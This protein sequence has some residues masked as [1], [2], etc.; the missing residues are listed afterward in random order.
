MFKN[1]KRMVF[2]APLSALSRRPRLYK[3]A[4]FFYHNKQELEI[5]HI[6]WERNKGER[7]EID[8]NFD[9]EKRIILNGGGYGGIKVKLYYFIWIVK[10]FFACLKLKKTDIVWALGF[11]SAFP[12]LLASKI[13]K[14]NVIFDDADRFSMLFSFPK[15]IKYLIEFFEKFTSRNVQKHLIPGIERYDFSSEKF[16]ILKNMPSKVE[17]EKAKKIYGSKVWPKADL[18]INI[19]G[20][21]QQNRGLDIALEL[22]NRLKEKSV[23]FLVAGRLACNEAELLI[24]NANVTYFGK[25]S[26]AE[27]L[28]SYFA[29]DLV[30]TY[31]RP[32]SIINTLAESNKWGDAIKIGIGVIVNSEVKTANYLR[33][34]NACIYYPYNDINSLEN[35]ISKLLLNKI[36]LD[37]LKE[38]S[39]KL[40][41][42]FDYFEDQL[43]AIV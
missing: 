13:K 19:N 34:N 27:A 7:D 5:L 35:E 23:H 28:A 14:F 37:L 40:F 42:K 4:N 36:N 39:K 3:I 18:I 12:A 32:D 2:L 1:K 8:L 43:K 38:N 29:S 25:V 41:G 17:V 10:S 21:L 33:E 26:N 11:E 31:F 30:L 6:G 9:I 24:D 15:P 20:L 22:S 16:H